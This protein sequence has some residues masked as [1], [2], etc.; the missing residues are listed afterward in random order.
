MK[1][2]LIALFSVP[3]TLMSLLLSTINGVHAAQT[4]GQPNHPSCVRSVHTNRLVCTRVTQV[5]SLRKATATAA[6]PK[7]GAMLNFTIEESD[8]A[9]ALFGCDCPR[10][11]NSLRQLRGQPPLVQG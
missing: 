4:A 3:T 10:C 8:A 11:L 2:L 7:E 5:S 9:V 6:K 1:R